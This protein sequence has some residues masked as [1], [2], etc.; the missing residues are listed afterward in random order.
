VTQ[1]FTLADAHCHLAMYADPEAVADRATAAGVQVVAATT[2]ASEY[3][4]LRQGKQPAAWLGLGLHPECAGSVYASFELDIFE[5]EVATAS[6]I[7]EVGLDGRIARQVSAYFGGMPRM[8]AQRQLFGAVLGLAGPDRIYCVH[9]RAAV[10]AVLDML[11]AHDCRRVVLHGFDGEPADA[12]KAQSAGYY[13][14]IHPAMLQTERHRELIRRLPARLLLLETDG[15]FF[16]WH[17]G[18]IEP[19][20]CRQILAAIAAVRDE[21]PSAVEENLARNFADLT[22]PGDARLTG[23]HH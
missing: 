13:F 12:R 23:D 20:H 18:R 3:R 15:P 16:G 17:A 1:P 11:L 22:L 9:S 21:P 6:W 8:A 4:A 5:R 10:P 7:S 14:S 19:A 2:R